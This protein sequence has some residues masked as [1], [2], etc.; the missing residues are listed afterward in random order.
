[1]RR[2]AHG[3]FGERSGETD[4]EQ[5]RH[6]APGLLSDEAGQGLRPPRGRTW[7]RRGKTPIVRVRAAGSG[8][9][10]IAGVVAFR[11][12]EP[13]APRLIFRTIT[14][15]G[16]K[17]EPKGFTESDYARLLDAVHQQLGGPIVL[18][19]DNLNRHKSPLMRRLI[20]SRSRLT[21]FYLPTYAPELNPVE[22]VW[23]HMKGSLVN[24]TRR[25]VDQLSTT[26]KSR[27]RHLQYRRPVLHG[28]LAKTHLDLDPPLP[29]L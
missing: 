7:G 27:L 17:N 29:P 26:V 22:A 25:T 13:D 12:Q 28:F 5:S 24:F 6:R 23:S 11:P 4:R 15:H 10:S 21:V 8:R 9:V 16:R 18:I 19:W 3:G 1:L 20:T 2:E 14:H